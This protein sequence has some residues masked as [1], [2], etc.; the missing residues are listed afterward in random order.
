MK[1]AAGA[2]AAGSVRLKS[3]PAVFSDFMKT[4]AGEAVPPGKAG[5][6]K[7]RENGQSKQAGRTAGRVR[8]NRDFSARWGKEAAAKIRNAGPPPEKRLSA[9]L[10]KT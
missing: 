4:V 3:G 10:K 2:A 5:F 9:R 8:L 7:I 1:T 6:L